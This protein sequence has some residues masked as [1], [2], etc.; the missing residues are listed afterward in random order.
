MSRNKRATPIRFVLLVLMTATTIITVAAPVYAQTGE[1]VVAV[2]NGRR[3]KQKEVDDTIAA[4]L[5]PLQQQINALR[6]KALDNLLLRAIL[7]DEA[8]KRGISV[9]DLRKQLTAGE[10]EVS[11]SQVEQL[12]LENASTFAA[13]SPDEAK[14]RL[15]LDLE[16][17]ARMRNY[18]DALSKLKETSHIESRLEGP[19]LL[20]VSG[21][22][23][24]PSQGP[25]GALV[26][27]IAFSDFQCSYCKSAHATI[28]RVLQEYGNNVRL[29]FKHLPLTDTHPQALPAAQAA[30]CAGEQGSFWP[31]HDALFA[32]ETLSSE[33]F[34]KMAAQLDLNLPKFKA[35]LDSEVS[36]ATIIKDAQEARRI[37]ITGT[38]AF[39]ING[40][41]F[42][43][44]LSFED[45]K[46]IIERE[47]KSNRNSPPNK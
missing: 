26:T 6:K 14:E 17:Q 4:Q 34:A 22:D 40:N 10:V 5:L 39:I 1:E 15:R 41:L 8:K 36:R 43:G 2:V 35:C 33:A 30:F 32:S 44:A 19:R 37:G 20:T 46:G 31:Y 28:K 13:M 12:Y 16:S 21:V 11:P 23:I 47:L 3:I 42:R 7:E 24:A 29:I 27:I 45:F 9:E 38:P 25:K 18:R